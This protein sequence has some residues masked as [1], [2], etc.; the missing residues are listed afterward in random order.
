M[1]SLPRLADR[2]AASLLALGAGEEEQRLEA[3]TSTSLPALRRPRRR[4]AASA[5]RV[6]EAHRDSG[7]RTRWIRRSRSPGS[8]RCGRPNGTAKTRRRRAASG[9]TGIGCPPATWRGWRRSWAPATRRLQAWAT[10]SRPPSVSRSSRGQSGRL[11]QAG[12]QSLAQRRASGSHRHLAPCLGV[13]RPLSSLDSTYS[14][15]IEHL[16][17]IAADGRF[18][19]GPAR[20]RIVTRFDSLSPLPR[21]GSR[22]RLPS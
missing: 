19:W 3:L 4:G 8:A 10:T 21:R 16:G 1:D 11:V 18:G 2:L 22:P 14:P 20:A 12:R 6:K 7:T 15:A 9:P 5:R 17:E 13:V